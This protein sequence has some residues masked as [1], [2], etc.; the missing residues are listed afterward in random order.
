MKVIHQLIGYFVDRGEL[1]NKQI[2]YLSEKGYWAPQAPYDL[3]NLETNIGAKYFFLVTGND[4][5]PLWGTDVYTSDSNI[6]TAAVH[7]GLLA[8]DETRILQVTIETPLNNYN[9]TTRNGVHSDHWNYWPGAFT[10]KT[11]S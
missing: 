10:L 3:R 9:G 8:L 4:Q 2:D 5:G 11:L 1:T 6:G 7:A